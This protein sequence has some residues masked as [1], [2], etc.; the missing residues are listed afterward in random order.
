VNP[1][2]LYGNARSNNAQWPS[3]ISHLSTEAKSLKDGQNAYI[4]Q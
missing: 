3:D 1:N 4:S 2:T